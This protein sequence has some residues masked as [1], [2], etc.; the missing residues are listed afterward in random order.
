MSTLREMMPEAAFMGCGL[1][2]L[3]ADEEESLRRWFFDAAARLREGEPRL[4]SVSSVMPGGR[5]LELDDGSLWRIDDTD[6]HVVDQWL[7]GDQIL[8]H[9]DRIYRLDAL[10]AAGAACISRAHGPARGEPDLFAGMSTAEAVADIM[11]SMVGQVNRNAL[12]GQSFVIQFR[13]HGDGGGDY[14]FEVRDGTPQMHT[15][16]HPHPSMTMTLAARDYVDLI[17]GRLHGERAFLEGRLKISGD[18]SLAARMQDLFR[19]P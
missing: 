12:A 17:G 7:L 4:A 6:A 8:V 9:A 19:Q 16:L 15:G 3:T 2:K 18:M 13:L 14:Y 10:E 5:T 11:T 1:H